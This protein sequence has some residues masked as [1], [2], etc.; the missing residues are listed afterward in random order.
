MAIIAGVNIPD[1]KRV[2][3][4]LTS[5]Y[6]IGRTM[7]LDVINQAGI[8]DNPRVRDLSDEDLN[9]MREIIDKGRM[10][11]GDLRREVNQNIR[12][13]IDIGCY[14]GTRHRRGLPTRGQRT[15]TNAR[16]KRGRKMAVSRKH[17]TTR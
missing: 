6:G 7:A 4:A 10:V 13:L 9:R 11:E 14:R 3:T 16:A 8:I 15:K 17:S 12:R 2:E 5:I 1:A